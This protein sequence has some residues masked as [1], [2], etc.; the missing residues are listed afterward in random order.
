MEHKGYV[1][2]KSDET[3]NK[4]K[5]KWLIIPQDKNEI[6]MF[7]KHQKQYSSK[8]AEKVVPLH[9]YCF[10]RNLPKDS[11]VKK[12]VGFVLT[13]RLPGAVAFEYNILA[14]ST[15]D[16]ELWLRAVLSRG[17]KVEE[18]TKGP[19]QT[20]HEF[21]QKHFL[22]SVPCN[23][24][25]SLID[26][27]QAG[28]KCKQCNFAIH[29]KCEVKMQKNQVVCLQEPE[30]NSSGTNSL[31][32]SSEEYFPI[33]YR[34]SVSLSTSNSSFSDITKS[35]SSETVPSINIG[36]SNESSASNNDPADTKLARQNSFDAR[37]ARATSASS[38]LV[39]SKYPVDGIK[40]A[41]EVSNSPAEGV[42][43]A[44]VIPPKPS[45]TL[46]A[47]APPQKTSQMPPLPGQPLPPLP[48]GAL[49]PVPKQA[50]PPVPTKKS[51]ALD[52]KDKRK[53]T[54]VDAEQAAKR[55]NFFL[56]QLNKKPEEMGPLPGTSKSLRHTMST[57]HIAP[58][59][60]QPVTGISFYGGKKLK[61]QGSLT[62][63][64]SHQKEKTNF[65]A[66]LSIRWE[67]FSQALPKRQKAA[68][69]YSEESQSV[70]QKI[71]G[72]TI[73]S[74]ML[75]MRVTPSPDQPAVAEEPTPSFL[76]PAPPPPPMPNMPEGDTNKYTGVNILSGGAS[77]NIDEMFNGVQRRPGVQAFRIEGALP[78]QVLPEDNGV[79]TF[80]SNDCY[81]V[82]NVPD[83]DSGAKFASQAVHIW[84]GKTSTVDK[85]AYA[86]IRTVQLCSLFLE[87]LIHLR[88][89]EGEESQAFLS[90]FPAGFVRSEGGSVNKFRNYSETPI[91][92]QRITAFETP[93]L[94]CVQWS[95]AKHTSQN[96]FIMQVEAVNT[97]LNDFDAFI[98]DMNTQMYVFVGSRAVDRGL[99]S[100]VTLTVATKINT[101]ERNIEA[102]IFDLTKP[103]M[104]TQIGEFWSL[105]GGVVDLETTEEVPLDN[106]NLLIRTNIDS[107]GKLFLEPLNQE[108]LGTKLSRAT[109]AHNHC[110]VLDCLTTIYIW[111]GN[112]STLQERKLVR[113][114]ARKIVEQFERPP[115]TCIHRELDGSESVIFK[116][117]FSDW[118]IDIKTQ[119]AEIKAKA[120]KPR[121]APVGPFEVSSLFNEENVSNTSDEEDARSRAL[122]EVEGNDEVWIL[123]KMV[124]PTFVKLEPED[125]GHF[126]NGNAYMVIFTY[127]EE[128]TD[129]QKF[130]CYFWEGSEMSRTAYNQ[131]SSLWMAELQKKVSN[132]AEQTKVVPLKEPPH[133]AH[134]FNNI[135]I[136]HNGKKQDAA[137]TAKD[138]QLYQIRT[139][140]GVI[141]A[142]QI[143]FH[144]LA[145]DSEY[146][147][148]LKLENS[149]YV[150]NGKH[151]SNEE[152]IGDVVE[153]LK[154]DVSDRVH[155]INEDDQSPESQRF[156]AELSN[157]PVISIEHKA[158]LFRASN[159]SG[160]FAAEQIRDFSQS[161]I[162]K[163]EIFFLD[164]HDE[165]Y[166]LPSDNSSE[167]ERQEGSKVVQQ[168]ADRASE[169]RGTKIPVIHVTPDQI[170]PINFRRRFFAYTIRESAMDPRQRSIL[171]HQE[172][173]RREEEQR[174]REEQKRRELEEAQKKARDHESY[175]SRVQRDFLVDKEEAENLWSKFSAVAPRSQVNPQK[176]KEPEV[177][178]PQEN[179][180]EPDTQMQQPSAEETA[181]T[182]E[183]VLTTAKDPTPH[184]Q[185]AVTKKNRKKNK[186]AKATAV[187]EP[188]TAKAAVV[189]PE[190]NVEVK[191]EVSTS[192]EKEFETSVNAA[193]VTDITAEPQ[194]HEVPSATEETLPTVEKQPEETLQT[195]PPVTAEAAVVQATP[196][197]IKSIPPIETPQPE[198]PIESPSESPSESPQSS[199]RVPSRDSPQQGKALSPRKSKNARKKQKKKKAKAQQKL[200]IVEPTPSKE[201][202]GVTEISKSE[203]VPQQEAAVS[204]EIP[205][206]SPPA[207]ESLG[208][209][210]TET[211]AEETLTQNVA[212]QPATSPAED[213]KSADY[214]R[215]EVRLTPVEE[216]LAVED[217]VDEEDVKIHPYDSPRGE[218]QAEE[219][220]NQVVEAETPKMEVS[221]EPPREELDEKGVD[222]VGKAVSEFGLD[223][224]TARRL[225][226]SLVAPLLTEQA[227]ELAK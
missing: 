136:V 201:L 79:V 123:Q 5:K 75:R 2:L 107:E 31:Q 92:T 154:N 114:T 116:L 105:L 142:A 189:E 206:E 58:Q 3:K 108:D 149:L 143:S 28:L 150:W 52:W 4:W 210:E 102:E 97:S 164:T 120:E 59:R 220:Q 217:F 6:A 179:K 42:K 169:I 171:R 135:V 21:L 153:L 115:Y 62:D 18:E 73:V 20:K 14:D 112:K 83:S 24:C 225:W 1:H 99:L 16:R 196:E 122:L 158:K 53:T 181:P 146:S 39:P 129:V 101:F 60:R 84:I 33:N 77:E 144:D 200:N 56:E 98:L 69:I 8:N 121:R 162:T 68:G 15:E 34:H 166:F 109:L 119:P 55:K 187:L 50:L 106:H 47:P 184:A 156:M 163:E 167:G 12:D 66:S 54:V 45:A 213:P 32:S 13:W 141:S 198:S 185:P 148:L 190:P 61:R 134:L 17:V 63:I 193:E 157:P 27:S 128:K 7:S 40:D 94:Y 29:K 35:S 41:T 126:Y 211:K 140:N 46:L 110:Y 180:L 10:C 222:F 74:A 186:K 124:G 147:Y 67:E 139:K 80:Y 118:P 111:F 48:K 81:L 11:V 204:S 82:L 9:N 65:E 138:S 207:K 30:K 64:K 86:A 165:I 131:W 132:N 44:P 151:S 188:E 192:P 194:Q 176:A 178:P 177:A 219:T 224:Q 205:V 145:L 130:Q 43:H 215:L 155:V 72:E 57:R 227:K 117:K 182:P 152:K 212:E 208:V 202:E 38:T 89:E 90:H 88:E 191:A 103:D 203:S 137:K 160:A 93:R 170:P 183:K 127:Y 49:P 214:P 173:Q 26:I 209:P 218:I 78:A 175:V 36:G 174:R 96:I 223:E 172:Q 25:H 195:E 37:R 91:S 161:D 133:F 104:D 85:A 125:R 221:L 113:E 100:F 216:F 159:K 23:V 226:R 199:P 87:K 76:E 70:K 51:K 22:N 197:E 168:Y 19:A 95:S 71:D